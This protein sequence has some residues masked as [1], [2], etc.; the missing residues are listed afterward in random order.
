MLWYFRTMWFEVSHCYSAFSKQHSENRFIE[1]IFSMQSLACMR[2]SAAG[3]G[4]VFAF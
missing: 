1:V 2:H 4:T 3:D